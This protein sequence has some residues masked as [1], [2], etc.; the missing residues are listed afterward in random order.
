MPEF[1]RSN[2][3]T[4][5]SKRRKSSSFLDNS[6]DE[7]ADEYV[8][9][10]RRKRDNLPA[11]KEEKRKSKG[12]KKSKT[13]KADIVTDV[14][15]V[16]KDDCSLLNYEAVSADLVVLGCVSEITPSGVT[17]SLP[18]S[19]FAVAPKSFI[20]PHRDINLR[21]ILSERQ[22]VV[23]K[24]ISKRASLDNTWR[25]LVS[26]DPANVNAHIP[27][28]AVDVG[29][30]LMGVVQSVE[31][32]G[33]V[34][35]SG[36]ANLRTFLS[37]KAAEN[38]CKTL[39]KG[40]PLAVGQLIRCLVSKRSSNNNASNVELTT[41]LDASKLVINSNV[42]ISNVLPGSFVNCSVKRILSDGVKVSA[43]GLRCPAFVNDLHRSS[44][45]KKNKNL[46][47]QF[48]AV[49]LYADTLKNKVLLGSHSCLQSLQLPKAEYP[50]KATID[51]AKVES[52][53]KDGVVV[54]FLKDG[55]SLKGVI[56]LS[57]AEKLI[58]PKT[59][60]T[61][62]KDTATNATDSDYASDNSIED[63]PA[64]EKT[65]SQSNTFNRLQKK[66]KALKIIPCCIS[67]YSYIDQI[68]LCSVKSDFEE[69]DL[70]LGDLRL[71]TRP[72][73]LVVGRK[74]SVTIT[75]VTSQFICVK[76]NDF[77]IIGV[78]P[79]SELSDN[80][81]LTSFLFQSYCEDD[82]IEKAYFCYFDDNV[83]VFSV[84]PSMMQFF[85][86]NGDKLINGWSSVVEGMRI[87]C[88]VSEVI[89]RRVSG[90][91]VST[92]VP[93]FPQVMVF[94][95]NLL[96]S[97]L[98]AVRPD[99]KQTILSLVTK[100]DETELALD[101]RLHKVWDF[102]LLQ[103]IEYF[104]EFL[105]EMARVQR[106]STGTSIQCTASSRN[107]DG[108][109]KLN[110]SVYTG[111]HGHLA[112]DF[113]E[114]N[115]IKTG[116]IVNA[117]VL[118]ENPAE[119][120]VYVCNKNAINPELDPTAT[121]EGSIVRCKILYKHVDF[122]IG[123]IVSD[124][125]SLSGQAVYVLTKLHQNDFQRVLS[126]ISVKVA[127]TID[128]QI[129]KVENSFILGIL[130]DALEIIK[131]ESNRPL[132]TVLDTAI[133]IVNKSETANKGSKKKKKVDKMEV[134]GKKNKLLMM[135]DDMVQDDS[136][137]DEEE[138]RSPKVNGL[139]SKDKKDKTPKQVLETR[140]MDLEDDETMCLIDSS[141][142]RKSIETK[143]S[144]TGFDWNA[145]L[146]TL[147]ESLA[148][149]VVSEEEE[150]AEVPTKKKKKL[151]AAE[152]RELSK[153]KEAKIRQAEEELLNAEK[154][155]QSA[156]HFDRLLLASPNESVL[157][158]KYM[159]YHLQGTE[160]EKAKSVA[161]RALETINHREEAERL[162][163]WSAL[164]NLENMYGTPESFQKCFTEALQTNDEWS[165]YSRVM[166]IYVTSKK[167]KELE[168][169][170]DLATK[171]LR[172]SFDVYVQCG[173]FLLQ[174][175]SI[176]KS[177]SIMQRALSALPKKQHVDLTVRFA[178]LENR[179][180]DQERAQTLFEHILT[181]FPKRIDVWISYVDLLTKANR[182]DLARQVIERGVAQKLKP[183][184]MKSLYKKW[185]NFE[186]EHG[187]PESV[188]D[189]KEEI[190]K[191][192]GVK[193]ED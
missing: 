12:F 74:F 145:S 179:L 107:S 78:I 57:S 72:D 130:T 65:P 161:K 100:H 37:T 3:E 90:I 178:H 2:E 5:K 150:V 131:M 11:A 154:N 144:D 97:D 141:K 48:P 44:K 112:A 10:K 136:E 122:N 66:L 153:Q 147:Q 4:S 158:I 127:D 29:M 105:N 82:I 157:W 191:Y 53:R 188:A 8:K 81:E 43:Q 138:K 80:L 86:E 32:H 151:S 75:K 91:V 114:E 96:I 143:L 73:W 170:V 50:N 111:I 25:V 139:K 118:W 123:V 27:H 109:W 33:Y 89:D 186:K 193:D 83:P 61:Q 192:A 13:Y 185:L 99:S 28:Y 174:V 63:T 24:V 45:N 87:P 77:D 85:K 98:P 35:D 190:K 51:S 40:K 18:G 187:T 70:N 169:L 164:L 176:E 117:S 41:E 34:I 152:R 95:E 54:K 103:S 30:S 116:T 126:Q 68:Y 163:V 102:N 120:T 9:A 168:K 42:N 1:E 142:P 22:L 69:A 177:R 135:L 93:S 55:R 21:D 148:G 173:E 76:V 31:D 175:G 104:L 59:P 7:A 149:D 52:V 166:Q 19:I 137:D 26:L 14:K 156:D 119:N 162:N 6:D 184:K 106:L 94:D 47:A 125:K 171:K 15:I 124:D 180:G 108:S 133:Q 172:N 189:V 183:Q 110:F 140:K 129:L 16:T 58:T 134:G 71:K 64:P 46:N 92:H 165:V 132:D 146:A 67:N 160:I 56:S 17:I 20:T 36:I 39:N 167:I 181:T 62:T 159:A 182:I 115:K 49:I 155:P 101:C 84:K 23:C 121:K 128:V 38:W 60:E 79:T 113:C 88:I